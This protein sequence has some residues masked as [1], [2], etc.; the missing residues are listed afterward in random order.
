M[1]KD[2][3]LSLEKCVLIF[4]LNIC[5]NPYEEFRSIEFDFHKFYEDHESI[6]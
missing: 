3:N 1:K 4:F 6:S 5:M 2:L